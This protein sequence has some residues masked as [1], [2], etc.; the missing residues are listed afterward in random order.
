MQN[1]V[2]YRPALIAAIKAEGCHTYAQRV[3][4]EVRAELAASAADIARH[5][6]TYMLREEWTRAR[7]AYGLIRP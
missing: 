7:K 6:S 4:D 2:A 5:P 1:E 3:L